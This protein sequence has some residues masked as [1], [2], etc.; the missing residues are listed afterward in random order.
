MEDAKEKLDDPRTIN[1]FED[2]LDRFPRGAVKMQM[3]SCIK[4][5]LILS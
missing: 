1:E 3:T 2:A 4:H 5:P